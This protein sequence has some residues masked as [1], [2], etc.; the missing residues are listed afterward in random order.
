[1]NF[2]NTRIIWVGI[3]Y[4][5]VRVA[6]AGLQYS[7]ATSAPFCE[8]LGEEYVD[9]LFFHVDLPFQKQVDRRPYVALFSSAG[10]WRMAV[11]CSYAVPNRSTAWEMGLQSEWSPRMLRY[12]LPCSSEMQVLQDPCRDKA[13]ASLRYARGR[14]FKQ[15]IAP[16]EQSSQTL[17]IKKGVSGS[18]GKSLLGLIPSNGVICICI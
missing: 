18:S 15:R 11:G 14:P 2:E 5:L 1:M 7:G 10:E 6:V 17:N 12:T 9:P 16:K 8:F 4:Q 3:R 13:H